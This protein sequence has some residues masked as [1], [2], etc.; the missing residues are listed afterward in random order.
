[1]DGQD[2][3]LKARERHEKTNIRNCE[4]REKSEKSVA[5]VNC[6][7][8]RKTTMLDVSLTPQHHASQTD[9]GRIE[10]FVIFSIH[11]IENQPI[12]RKIHRSS[13]ESG[14]GAVV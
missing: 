9:F 4:T 14:C 11:L 8:R 12:I 5:E 6:H 2:E 1:M 10:V 3:N 13:V 7:K